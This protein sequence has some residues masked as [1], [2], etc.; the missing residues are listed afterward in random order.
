MRRLWRLMVLAAGLTG[1]LALV[2][3][4]TSTDPAAIVFLCLEGGT[5]RNHC[6]P[7]RSC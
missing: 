7:C 5:P 1:V 2:A 3:G 4:A 6:E